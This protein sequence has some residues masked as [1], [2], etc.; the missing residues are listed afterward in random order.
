MFERFAHAFIDALFGVVS[1]C[2]STEPAAPREG[3][4]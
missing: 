2:A 4:R 3:W 1:L